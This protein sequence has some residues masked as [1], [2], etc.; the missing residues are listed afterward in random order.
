MTLLE[1]SI[2][3]W[4]EHQVADLPLDIVAEQSLAAMEARN[5]VY[6]GLLELMPTSGFEGK[7]VLDFGCGPGHDVVGFLLN[8]ARY[9]YAYD[10]SPK[11]RAMTAARVRAHGVEE[12]CSIDG[13]D[14]DKERIWFGIDHIHTAGVIHHLLRPVYMLRKLGKALTKGGEIRMMVYSSESDF[15]RRIAHGDPATFALLADGKAPITNAWTAEEVV[16]IAKEAG[17][18]AEYV[19]SYRHPGEIEGPGLSS[20]WSLRP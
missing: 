18:R 7:T 3:H 11:A 2:A 5:A 8:G 12:N 13:G 10:V 15:Y 19:G 17:L 4:S 14:P 20:C 6:P 9:V 1:D 16:A